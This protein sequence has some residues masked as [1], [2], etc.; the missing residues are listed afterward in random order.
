VLS[1]AAGMT[2]SNRTLITLADALRT[3]G[4]PAGVALDELGTVIQG[5]SAEARPCPWWGHPHPSCGGAPG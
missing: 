2:V 3:S 5:R 1:Y 4:R